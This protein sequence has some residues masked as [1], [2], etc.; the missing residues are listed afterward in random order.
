MNWVALLGTSEV[1]KEH[2]WTE[3]EEG[4]RFDV[5]STRWTNTLNNSDLG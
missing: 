1:T 5:N 2:D 4:G 3:T